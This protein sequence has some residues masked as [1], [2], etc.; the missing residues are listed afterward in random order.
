MIAFTKFTKYP[1][2]TYCIL[3]ICN[4]NIT[5]NFKISGN[6]MALTIEMRII[7]GNVVAIKIWK[8]ILISAFSNKHC[9]PS[10]MCNN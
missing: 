6:M 4:I 2:R 1:S 8:I 5:L 3:R 9:V 10:L 7:P